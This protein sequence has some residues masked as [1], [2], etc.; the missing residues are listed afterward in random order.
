MVSLSERLVN[1]MFLIFLGRKFFF[2]SRYP[3][4]YP[5]KTLTFLKK[6]FYLYVD[7]FVHYRFENDAEAELNSLNGQ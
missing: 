3:I 6:K 7:D 1:V 5:I 4:S 2:M